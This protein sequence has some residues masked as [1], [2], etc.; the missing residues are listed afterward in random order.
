MTTSR[1]SDGRAAATG[2]GSTTGERSPRRR[3]DHDQGFCIT[4]RDLELLG[5]VAAHRFVLACQVREWLRTSEVVAYRRLKGLVESGLL[6][7]RR[8]FHARPGCYQA[9]AA[10]LGV[11]ESPLPRA[12]IDLRTY[13]HDVGVVWV[14]LAASNDCFGAYRRV[15]SERQM[16]S[17][18]QRREQGDESFAIPLGSYT[19]GGQPRLHYPDVLVTQTGGRQIAIELELTLKSRS[20]LEEILTGYRA[21]PRIECVLYFTDSATIRTAVRETSWMLGLDGRVEIEYFAPAP[22]RDI[23]REWESLIEGEIER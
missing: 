11:I 12:T 10:G 17:H 13:R 7:Y 22:E 9:T 16:R 23:E 18:D 21:Q 1:P 4:H 8:I 15:L 5:M 6:S 14:W 19:P 3:L 20:R 2:S